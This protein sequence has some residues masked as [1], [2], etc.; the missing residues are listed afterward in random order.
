MQEL[1]DDELKKVEGGFE[2][3]NFGLTAICFTV[4]FVIGFFDG[5][6]RPLKCNS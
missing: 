4:P 3:S 1:K 6:M 2:I 5:L